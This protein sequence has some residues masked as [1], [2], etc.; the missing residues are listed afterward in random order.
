MPPD[1]IATT[2][3]RFNKGLCF[4][5]RVL[6]VASPATLLA[7]HAA[8]PSPP[9][10]ALMSQS[11]QAGLLLP[12]RTA[13]EDWPGAKA[14]ANNE[15]S[16]R[17]FISTRR[18][19]L[20]EWMATPRENGRYVS[21]I[22]WKLINPANGMPVTWKPD[23]P[24][25][26]MGN[27]P[28]EKD[29]WGAW[30]S[31]LRFNNIGR[32][33]DAAYL[34]RVTG[35]QKYAEWAAQQLDF[36]ANNYAAWP[37]QNAIGPSRMLGQLLDESTNAIDLTEVAR[38]LGPY[39]KTERAQRW[40]TQ[41]FYPIVATIRPK[42]LDVHNIA[43]WAEAAQACIGYLY[44]DKPLVSDAL[45]GPFG[46]RALLNAGVTADG[47]W[48]EGT[49]G[50]NQFVRLALHSLLQAAQLSGQGKTVADVQ[51]VVQLLA[52]S[53]FAF[54]FQDDY[55]PTPGDS[56]NRIDVTNGWNYLAEYRFAPTYF[57]LEKAASAK[58]WDTL[59]DPPTQRLPAKL[60]LPEVVTANFEG[61]RMAVLRA[62]EW[63]AFV[64]YGQITQ[65]HAQEEALTYELYKG[66]QPLSVDPGSVS[67][68]SPYQNNY[69]RRAVAQNVPMVDGVGQVNFTP[70]TVSKFDAAT[71][72]LVVDQPNYNADLA[73][74][75][76]YQVSA[77]G[78]TETTTLRL[79]DA[80]RG[81]RRLGVTFHTGCQIGQP[82]S[83]LSIPV[84]SPA[85]AGPG[86]DYWS[87]ISRWTA[88][89]VWHVPLTCGGSKF[90]LEIRGPAG[91]RVYQAT[92]P[93]TPLP[94]KRQVLYVETDGT[95]AQFT[96]TISAQ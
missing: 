85:P 70:G 2:A 35:E 12:Q 60:V 30:V 91:H 76:R 96:T 75:R 32:A 45:D 14:R 90:Q 22:G 93:T 95:S 28:A 36:Y 1:V 42:K 11:T 9:I 56:Q 38:L 51:S 71:H 48:Q 27:S 39:A 5:A 15:P 29:Y 82:D 88:P 87:P 89:A 46:V 49:F 18:T 31:N 34:Y 43:L 52:I 57:G 92:A 8:T 54:R 47:I 19:R 20:D 17:S 10:D 7:C 94:A 13:I 50:Y 26:P 69:F 63:Q 74:S 77:Q 24:E 81:A 44:A 86:F 58:T 59:V 21:G 65:N 33:V 37:A 84:P 61:T 4:L 25:P 40:K 66:R 64:H 55:L 72:L 23:M 73:A 16:W 80:T 6:I 78:F 67:Y 3:R 79:R 53:P 62:G 83:T 41:L 68:G